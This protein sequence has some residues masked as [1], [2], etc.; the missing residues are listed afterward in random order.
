MNYEVTVRS[1]P[2]RHVAVV[3]DRL[4]W[5]EL[6]TKLLPLL[7]RVYVAVRSGRVVQS[8]QNI[9]IYR[10][11][12]RDGVSVAVG[13]EIAEPF[14]PVDEVVCSETPAGEAAMT[15]HVG[16][17]SGLGDAHAAVIRWCN[18]HARIRAGVWW[19]IYGDWEADPARLQTE[20][21]YSLIPTG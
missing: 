13:V 9:F 7:D 11:G 17:Y 15:T 6:G 14:S 3:R 8:G 16:P 4:P 12:R 21:Y 5:S 1:V 18:E 20:V 2:K 10:D 19:E